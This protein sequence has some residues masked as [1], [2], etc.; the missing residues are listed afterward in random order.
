MA[1]TGDV[2]PVEVSR[3]ATGEVLEEQAKLAMHANGRVELFFEG[4]P[5]TPGALS[6]SGIKH[7]SV[8]DAVV[9]EVLTDETIHDAVRMWRQ[10]G[11][12][13]EAVEATFGPISD[14]NVSAVTNMERLF[15]WRNFNEDISKW[16]TSKVQ[17]T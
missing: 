2:F 16:N 17:N 7:G 5:V 15:E 3:D 14:W 4:N 1:I 11:S 13:R 8:V 6:E 12:G 10:G 9:V